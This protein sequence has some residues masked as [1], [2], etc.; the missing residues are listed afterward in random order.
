MIPE[1]LKDIYLRYQRLEHLDGMTPQNRGQQFNELI[2]DL[3]QASSIPAEANVHGIG[4]I[5]V[6]FSSGMRHFILEA[7]WEADPLSE[8]PIT[9]LEKR[10]KQRLSG[11][12]GILLSMSGYTKPALTNSRIGLQAEV[13]LLEREH[14]EAMLH[15]VHPA[16]LIAA[17]V[18]RASLRGDNHP[19]LTQLGLPPAAGTTL[20]ATT[21]VVA[22]TP[23]PRHTHDRTERTIYYTALMAGLATTADYEQSDVEPMRMCVT[24][25]GTESMQLLIKMRRDEQN[26]P[27]LF[28]NGQSPRHFPNYEFHSA[29]LAGLGL[30]T[31]KQDGMVFNRIGKYVL[32]RLSRS[33][34]DVMS[35]GGLDDEAGPVDPK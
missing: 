9:K 14:F 24:Q 30:L 19:S 33:L 31:E 20:T 29:Q 15:G 18:E 5:D 34:V 35:V 25:L 2:A 22:A 4:E 3:L 17:V 7:K 32:N 27:G 13:L 1:H 28:S 6:T 21:S 11:T 12:L 26:D 16:M 10:V 23:E 8:D